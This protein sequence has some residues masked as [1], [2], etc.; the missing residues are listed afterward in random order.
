MD[1]KNLFM[2]PTTAALVRAEYALGLLVALTLFLSH[3][4]DVRW[5]PAIGLFVYIDLI[6]YLP[7]A[8]QMRR[9]STGDLH[10]AYYIAYN[11]THSMLTQALVALLWMALLGPEWALLTLAIHLCGDR[12]LF[13]NFLKPFG[14]R[15]EPHQHPAYH[16]FRREF[17]TAHQTSH[18]RP[19]RD[20]S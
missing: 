3:L 12:A 10:K 19:A 20:A 7:G 9:S 18:R 4:H 14:V 17:S 16:R 5:E 8:I 1:A 13:G 6:G 2:T 11:V 15:F